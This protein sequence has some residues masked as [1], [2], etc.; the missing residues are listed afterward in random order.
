MDLKSQSTVDS[1]QVVGEGLCD[2]R[3]GCLAGIV[4]LLVRFRE[5]VAP[6]DEDPQLVRFPLRCMTVDEA[7]KTIIQCVLG[8]FGICNDIT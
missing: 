7:M 5:V 2:P 1:I 4:Q 8:E 6:E 3:V